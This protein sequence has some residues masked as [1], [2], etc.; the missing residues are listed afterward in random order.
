MNNIIEL[1]GVSHSFG[2]HKVLSDINLKIEKGEIIGLLGPSGAGKT[3]LIKIITGQLLP[4]NGKIS[5]NG[6]EMKGCKRDLSAIG[7][8]MDDWGLYGRLSIYD[9]LKFYA[10]IFNVRINK[11]DEVLIKV[12]LIDA[13]KIPVCNLSKGMKNRVNFCRALLKDID[14]LFLDEPTSGLDPTTANELHNM[15]LEQQKS[16]TTVFLTTHNMYEAQKLC[17]NVALL[18]NG[19]IVEYGEP[20]E[21]CKRYNHLNKII[22]ERKNRETVILNNNKECLAEL[23]SLIEQEEISTI[24][25]T[26][27]DLEKV[28]LELTGRRFV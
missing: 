6:I 3:T 21:I 14:I 22:V 26:E 27:P 2:E 5:I 25:S 18:N 15:I 19:K 12:G 28:F 20:L 17:S 24:H 8:M 16:G 7:I 10:R 23:V 13:K 1:S 4:N 11:I 9:N